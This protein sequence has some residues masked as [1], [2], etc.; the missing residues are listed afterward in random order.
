[1]KPWMIW[2]NEYQS[3]MCCEFSAAL[4]HAPPQFDGA[5]GA[6]R[7]AP[8][9]QQHGRLNRE[10]GDGDERAGP[11]RRACGAGHVFSDSMVTLRLV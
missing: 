4:H 11:Q 6:D 7:H 9:R 3:K 8:H 5:A 2:E 10:H 1:M